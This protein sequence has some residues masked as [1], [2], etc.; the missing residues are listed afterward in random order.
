[1]HLPEVPPYVEEELGVSESNLL[2][3][4]LNYSPEVAFSII[5]LR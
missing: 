3:Y 2:I 1:M 5:D 4:D